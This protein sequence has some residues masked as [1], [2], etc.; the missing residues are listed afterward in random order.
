MILRILIG[1]ILNT[2]TCKIGHNRKPDKHASAKYAP[3]KPWAVWWTLADRV[4]KG[5]CRLETFRLVRLNALK[6]I[7]PMT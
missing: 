4:L 1:V 6:W 5:L 3:E 7:H 2:S